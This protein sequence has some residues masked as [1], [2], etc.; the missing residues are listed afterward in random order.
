M[1]QP[2]MTRACM[3]IRGAWQ[4]MP[5]PSLHPARSRPPPASRTRCLVHPCPAHAS[6]RWRQIHPVAVLWRARVVLLARSRAPQVL[7][8]NQIRHSAAHLLLKHSRRRFESLKTPPHP[9]CPIYS[10]PVKEHLPTRAEH[11]LALSRAIL[12]R[13]RTRW[14]HGACS[15]RI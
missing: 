1:T 2:R 7:D 4:P 14:D 3:F 12:R 8:P 13:Y 11:A 5:T 10:V 15:W 9:P 6:H